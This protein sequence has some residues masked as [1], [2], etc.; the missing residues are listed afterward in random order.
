MVK[1]RYPNPVARCESM[2]LVKR[3]AFYK[4]KVLTYGVVGVLQD[5]FFHPYEVYLLLGDG[6]DFDNATVCFPNVREALEYHEELTEFMKGVC[7][8]EERS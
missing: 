5:K 8:V 3:S 6:K 1:K 7:G 2:T 4:F